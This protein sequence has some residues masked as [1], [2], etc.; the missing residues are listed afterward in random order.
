MTVWSEGVPDD[1]SYARY[2]D[3][4]YYAPEKIGLSILGEAADDEPWE[5]DMVVVWQN[6]DGDLRAAHDAGFSCPT[7]FGDLTWDGMKPI[8][9]I[10]DLDLLLAQCLADDLAKRDL[11]AKV[12][13]A[14]R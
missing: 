3:S 8:R 1:Y 10:E 11:Q 12:R 13:A 4:P 9:K 6:E 2:G 14:L 7:P 5:F